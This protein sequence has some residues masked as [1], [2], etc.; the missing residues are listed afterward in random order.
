MDFNT[1]DKLANAPDALMPEELSVAEQVYFLGMRALYYVANHKLINLDKAK[2]EKFDFKSKI[3]ILETQQGI[4][5]QGVR[6]YN[7]MQKLIAPGC[8]FKNKTKDELYSIICRLELLNMGIIEDACEDIP[9]QWCKMM[10]VNPKYK[11]K[12]NKGDKK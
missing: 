3:E 7:E 1:L 12:N 6:I 8:D 11:I 9:E 2:K 10:S 5:E 4:F